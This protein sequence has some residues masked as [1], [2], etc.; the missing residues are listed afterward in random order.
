MTSISPSTTSGRAPSSSVSEL[1]AV[2]RMLHSKRC[3]LMSS[4]SCPLPAGML[5]RA[6]SVHGPSSNF[7][8]GTFF[9]AA[10]NVGLFCSP[11]L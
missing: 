11:H 10:E 7:G 6:V 2:W 4:W 8:S 3:W 9:I 5:R 1:N